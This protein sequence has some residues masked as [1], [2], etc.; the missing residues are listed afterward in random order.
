MNVKLYLLLAALPAFLLL[1][2]GSAFAQQQV[3]GTVRDAETLDTLPGAT[4]LVKGTTI[5]AS[6]NLDG[7]YSLAV[8]SLTDTLVVS[9]VGYGSAE[10]PINGRTEIDVL[11]SESVAVGG[12]VVVVGY[13]QERERNITG[14]VTQIS[15]EDLADRQLGTL[16][17]A[18]QGRLPGVRVE[19]TGNP[20]AGAS[21]TIRGTSFTTGGNSPLYVVD[22]VYTG[23]NPNLNPDDIESLV[24]LKDASAAAQYGAQSANGVIL[25]TT[26]R[27]YNADQPQVD[28]RAYGGVQAMPSFI[29]MA[30]SQRWAEIMYQ[31]Y[32]NANDPAQPPPL[33]TQQPELFAN[34]DWEEEVF[35]PGTIQNYTLSVS[36]GGANSSY[37]I[38]GNYFDQEGI[39]IDSP[40]QRYTARV[41]SEV[42]RGRFTIGE[43]AT[44]VRSIKNN[45]SGAPAVGVVQMIPT[46]PVYDESQRGGFGIGN[47]DNPILN[48]N[49]VAQQY[50]NDNQN[51]Y[52][53]ALG[54]VYGEV[55]L[56]DNLKYR[57]NL[58]LEYTSLTNE[59]FRRQ[60][61]LRQ[62]DPLDPAWY[63]ETQD[64]FY[65]LQAE[66]LLT[67]DDQFGQHTINAVAGHR[68]ERSDFKTLMAYR[69]GYFDE[70]LRNINAGAENPETGGFETTTVLRS[71]FTR[72]NY[73]FRD[74]Y[75]LTGTVRRDGASAFGANNRWGT[76]ASFSAGWVVSDEPFFKAVPGLGSTVS[77]LKFRGG[78]GN[79]GN[80]SLDP[81]GQYARIALNQGYVFGA[82]QLAV[83]AIQLALA[84][85]NI[86]WQ[87]NESTNI[88][89]DLRM[90]NDRLTAEGDYFV[91]TS[92]NLLVSAPIPGS[93]GAYGVPLVNVGNIRNSG[94]EL[95]LGADLLRGGD[96]RLNLSANVTVPRSEVL[97]LGDDDQPIFA[98]PFGVS[99]TAVGGPVGALYVVEMDGIFQSMDE[100]LAHTATL[101]DG[102]VVVVQPNAQPGDVRYVDRNG[103]GIIDDEDRYV[104][105]SAV[106]DFEGGLFLS[107][108]YKA[109][110]FSFGLRG[111]YGVELF[112]VPLFWNAPGAGAGIRADAQPW[113]PENPSTT[114]PRALYGPL[115][116]SNNRAASD[117]WIEDGSYL[118][119][120]NIE[121]GYRLPVQTL[122]R[123]IGAPNATL[124]VYAS[125]ENALTLTG[126]SN[127]DP[128][129]P[130]QGALAP[131]V[132]DLAIYPAARTFTFGLDANF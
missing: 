22:G 117:R 52:N 59:A 29:G 47:L 24:V 51:Y 76:F 11:L 100:V 129:T 115:A 118:R 5:G 98:G 18:I 69:E 99:R 13:T 54:G 1:S 113:T 75:L 28:F 79:L 58:G 125:V 15:S 32:V 61:A 89:F 37:L 50:L 127:W 49:P 64:T 16:E 41:N 86:R 4:V 65:R 83:G 26:K 23:Q 6:T 85:P 110:D 63:R 9:F 111:V 104:A 31:A 3:S 30:D 102:T 91:A 132:D 80:A 74:R 105:G 55:Q 95:G 44:F 103:D 42:R 2:A 122:G 106:P 36:G 84:N 107:G 70:D 126:Y 57:G 19:T 120:Q 82:D 121:V 45:I 68:N 78:Y 39:I 40:F 21:V 124:R 12:E 66:N 112:N 7:A 62:N 92:N 119:V 109:V 48:N 27:G 38:S 20:G 34:T 88:G 71:F 56:F 35:Q 108:G 25:I 10:V 33:S 94:F 8:P 53:R 46:V 130:G 17:Q 90:F 128:A 96:G 60:G 114:T 77:F 101:A 43:T 72:A 116:A 14:A 67:F 93:L 123:S 73:A 87:G 97:A 81:Y 131:A